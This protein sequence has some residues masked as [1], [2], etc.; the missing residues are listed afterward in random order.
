MFT[1]FCWSRCMP[2]LSCLESKNKDRQ[3]WQLWKQDQT[4]IILPYLI[5]FRDYLYIHN[6]FFISSVK[7]L[8]ISVSFRIVCCCG[9]TV[10]VNRVIRSKTSRGIVTTSGVSEGGETELS[11]EDSLSRRT[12]RHSIDRTQNNPE[13]VVRNGG[14]KQTVSDKSPQTAVSGNFPYRN[15]ADTKT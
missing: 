13:Y 2:F 9:N 7:S 1:P 10:S 14:E 15:S 3:L 12:E 4:L 11:S 6:Y 5:P 8:F